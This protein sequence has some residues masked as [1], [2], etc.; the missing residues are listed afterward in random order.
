MNPTT[1]PSVHSTTTTTPTTTPATPTTPT[2]PTAPGHPTSRLRRAV[3]VAAFTAV[4]IG[5]GIALDLGPNTYL[6]LGI[7]LTIAFQLGVRR[8]PL[9][10]LWVRDG[11]P[12]VLNGP[13]KLVAAGLAVLPLI[14]LCIA[15]S[16]HAWVGAAWMAACLPGAAAAG[17]AITRLRG[18]GVAAGARFALLAF[19]TGTAIFVLFL[20]PQVI[21]A[22]GS[23][24]GPGMLWTGVQSA[25]LYLPVTFVLE[26]V[27]FRGLLDSH[28]H[29][30]GESR[31]FVSALFVSALWG[32]WHL[33]EDLGSEPLPTLVVGLLVVH[34]AIG[35]SLSFSWRRA[36]NLALPAAAHAAIDGVRNALQTGI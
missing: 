2:T 19:A 9:R 13:A 22:P 23:P 3:E 26:E 29:H 12:F 24:D 6:L 7:P 1:R 27:T 20:V 31:G 10:E 18:P 33:P 15:I 21:T 25:L 35:V 30:P 17:Y 34:C 4:W 14:W 5:L 11:G 28:L 32:M 8:R 16:Q 36:G